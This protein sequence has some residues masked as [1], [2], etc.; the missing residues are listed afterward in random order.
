[1]AKVALN[2]AKAYD[3]GFITEIEKSKYFQL[4]K[5]STTRADLYS[6]AIAIAMMEEKEPSAPQL[7]D[8]FVRTEYLGNY[9][10][11]LSS[12]YFDTQLK[13]NI[14]NIDNICKRDDVYAMAEKYANTG[15]GILKEWYETMD[16]EALYFKLIGYMNDRYNAIIEEV[17]SML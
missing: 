9:E 16:E 15:F 12:I 5:N 4:N 14:E 3:N 8:S 6:F 7:V 1:M 17:T 10:A 2:I 13:G 11:L